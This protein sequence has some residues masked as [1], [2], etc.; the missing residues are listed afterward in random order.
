VGGYFADDA[1]LL[2]VNSY[3]V[4]DAGISYEQVL[5]G[6]FSVR[7]FV[8]GLNLLNE[9]YAASVWINPDDSGAKAA[10]L[11]AGLPRNFSVGLNLTWSGE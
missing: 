5:T 1:N 3:T 11:E 7:G 9:K 2:P 6:G 10:F 4:L 8:R